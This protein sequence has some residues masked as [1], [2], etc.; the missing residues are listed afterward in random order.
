MGL[1]KEKLKPQTP[2]QDLK[3]NVLNPVYIAQS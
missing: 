1:V 3:L 2:Q